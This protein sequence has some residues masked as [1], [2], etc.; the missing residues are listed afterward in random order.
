[1]KKIYVDTNIFLDYLFDRMVGLVPASYFAERLF[2]AIFDC[3][4]FL[5]ISELTIKELETHSKMTKDMLLEM[6]REYED[7]GKLE[8]L[9]IDQK[10]IDRAK[11]IAK[12]KKVPVPDAIHAILAQTAGTIVVTRDKHFA[13]LDFIKAWKPEELEL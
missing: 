10:T 9:S 7:V 4:Y 13:N 3:K 6:F 11:G 8:I 1:M 2:D 12:E 5:I